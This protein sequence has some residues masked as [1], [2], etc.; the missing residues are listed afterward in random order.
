[1]Y[2]LCEDDDTGRYG[3]HSYLWFTN[4]HTHTRP[5]REGRKKERRYYFNGQKHRDNNKQNMAQYYT[6]YTPDYRMC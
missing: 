2:V 5:D 4:N 3:S 1:M 6:E